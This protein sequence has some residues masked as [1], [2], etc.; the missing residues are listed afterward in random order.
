[1]DFISNRVEKMR[2]FGHEM[3]LLNM[4]WTEKK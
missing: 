3:K 1:M 2:K 4:M